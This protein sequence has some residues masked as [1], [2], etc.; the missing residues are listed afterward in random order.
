M[1]GESPISSYGGTYARLA[2]PVVFLLCL[3][4]LVSACGGGGGATVPPVVPGAYSA[5]IIATKRSTGTLI[6]FDLYADFQ[7]A[8]AAY[9]DSG[10][11]TMDLHNL[12]DIRITRRN[13]DVRSSAVRVCGTNLYSLDY[14][15]P[16]VRSRINTFDLTV[17]PTVPVK[18]GDLQ[19]DLGPGAG[20]SCAGKDLLVS[21]GSLG[22]YRIDGTD[23]R[24]P[25]ATFL[26]NA[27]TLGT[28]AIYG[29]KTITPASGSLP[30]QALAAVELPPDP[31]CFPPP[32]PSCQS[33]DPSDPRLGRVG[34]STISVSSGEGS[35]NVRVPRSRSIDFPFLAGINTSPINYPLAAAV[36]GNLTMIVSSSGSRFTVYRSGAV[37]STGDFTGFPASNIADIDSIGEI[38]VVADGDIRVVDITDPTVPRVATSLVTPGVTYSLRLRQLEDGNFNVYAADGENGLVV[39]GIQKVNPVYVEAA[40]VFTVAGSVS[41]IAMMPPHVPTSPL[42]SDPLGITN[43]LNNGLLV[44]SRSNGTAVIGDN[45]D[46]TNGGALPSVN[47]VVEITGGTMFTTSPPQLGLPGIIRTL[48]QNTFGF[49]DFEDPAS[50]NAR[51]LLRALPLVRV[52]PI[53]V[54]PAPPAAPVYPDDTPLANEQMGPLSP[55]HAPTG[56]AVQNDGYPFVV[57]S[58]VNLNNPAQS[59]PLIAGGRAASIA[60]TGLPLSYV[61]EDPNDPLGALIPA[62]PPRRG[63]PATGVWWS[64]EDLRACDQLPPG[65]NALGKAQYPFRLTAE[66]PG[67]PANSA[68][69]PIPGIPAWTSDGLN[70]GLFGVVF[71]GGAVDDPQSD[72][73]L[74][75]YIDYY[76]RNPVYFAATGDGG[77]I[78]FDLDS[79]ISQ[80]S[81]P[82]SL[83]PLIP[84]VPCA[85]TL[86]VTQLVTD[87]PGMK[88]GMLFNGD[89]SK[90]FVADPAANVVQSISLQ[91]LKPGEP[92]GVW[93]RL[94]EYPL[95]LNGLLS[96]PIDLAPSDPPAKSPDHLR[97]SSSLY[98]LNRGSS[99]IVMAS[100]A[101]DLLQYIVPRV[102][103]VEFQPATFTALATSPDG[104]NLFLAVENCPTAGNS[105][106]YE[107][108]APAAP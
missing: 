3:V 72:D 42:L 36:N 41:D 57:S 1:F 28:V 61:L 7:V 78:Q 71:G 64:N 47:P 107:L 102:K 48:A 59:E 16:P 97:S 101:G 85:A 68:C 93:L 108:P 96:E 52:P 37:I 89:D 30:T 62:F 2:H 44:L 27:V 11:V 53:P 20:L 98:I 67:A 21:A 99:S 83:R 86:P 32:V 74:S 49:L 104:K 88:S 19:I 15:P 76:T 73:P 90:L 5:K 100:Q 65:T 25:V 10:L 4:L 31:A 80:V 35:D 66:V 9:G 23:L 45:I 84:N 55:F 26:G 70:N 6:N 24:N 51:L 38:A 103:G 87:D 46:R 17:D 13:D 12:D 79:G 43:F 105:C 91:K 14:Q 18:L 77:V 69:G 40:R 106:I 94:G 34:I 8:Y 81:P 58:G 22:L 54:Q 82:C 92:A 95:A 33:Q 56:I 39:I 63:G 50:L 60:P 75:P 29:L